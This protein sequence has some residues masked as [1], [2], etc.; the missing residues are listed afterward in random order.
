MTVDN[1]MFPIRVKELEKL[2]EK[3]RTLAD[4]H[5]L[6]SNMWLDKIVL[7]EKKLEKIKSKEKDEI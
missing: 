3:A 5:L 7:F 4:Y 2:I 1:E 6:T